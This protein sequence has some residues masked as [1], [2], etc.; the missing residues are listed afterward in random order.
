MSLSEDED[1]ASEVI[2][3]ESLFLIEANTKYGQAVRVNSRYINKETIFRL[4]MFNNLV[5]KLI[6]VFLQLEKGLVYLLKV[7]MLKV[8]SATER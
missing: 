2:S 3:R 7:F 6:D 1:F 5:W 8:T 4:L